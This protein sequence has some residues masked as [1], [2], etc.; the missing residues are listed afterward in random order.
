MN[1]WVPITEERYDEM[2]GVLPPASRSGNAFQVGEPTDHRNGRPT[3]ASFKRVGDQ[4][5]ESEESLT[6]AEF[7][8]EFPLAEWY[9]C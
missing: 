3:F 4:Y 9:G 2:L 8:A 1:K 5:F 7:K 6:F